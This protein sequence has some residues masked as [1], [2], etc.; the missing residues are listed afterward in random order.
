[1]CKSA[2]T[3]EYIKSFY[4]PMSNISCHISC[5]AQQYAFKC[6]AW[7]SHGFACGWRQARSSRKPRQL[8]WYLTFALSLS[9][10]RAI[11]L[12]R[13]PLYRQRM[14]HSRVLNEL[15]C[16]IPP[17][18]EDLE[19]DQREMQ[20]MEVFHVPFLTMSLTPPRLINPTYI[21]TCMHANTQSNTLTRITP[22]HPLPHTT[23]PQEAQRRRQDQ[24]ALSTMPHKPL[25]AQGTGPGE[26]MYVCVSVC[27][28]VHCFFL[29]CLALGIPS[30]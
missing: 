16:A 20:E 28:F 10:S 24:L 29:V 18:V 7:D 25:G 14:N 11:F 13:V 26:A 9:L 12:S 1:M 23:G 4:S 6:A 21:H 15:T 5:L 17:S 19:A 30:P 2:H 27:L 3:N 8:R 22:S